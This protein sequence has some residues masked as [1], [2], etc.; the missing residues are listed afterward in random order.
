MR[1]TRR[2]WIG[3]GLRHVTPL[4]TAPSDTERELRDRIDELTKRVSV[5]S[6]Q[7]QK[8]DAAIALKE[9]RW[10]SSK[11]EASARVERQWPSMEAIIRAVIDFYCVSQQE[12]LGKSQG[13]VIGRP[14]S[15]AMYLCRLL[16]PNSFPNIGRKFNRDHSTVMYAV[17][18]IETRRKVDAI[19]DRDITEI[20]RTLKARCQVAEAAEC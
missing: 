4:R 20:E 19:L 18:K 1:L 15:I 11:D 3:H 9:D 10:V 6:E 12:L 13:A 7:V 2:R 17:R 5:L 16:T 8:L 14:R